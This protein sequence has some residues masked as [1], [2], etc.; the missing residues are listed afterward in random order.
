MTLKQED[1]F[2]EGTK[3]LKLKDVLCSC[4]VLHLPYLF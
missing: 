1:F 2:W 3:N 4:N